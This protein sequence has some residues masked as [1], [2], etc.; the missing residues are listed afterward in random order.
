MPSF[1]PT[2]LRPLGAGGRLGILTSLGSSLPTVRRVVD[3]VL[4][5]LS[6]PPV[7]I[8]VPMSLAHLTEALR[9]AGF[10]RATTWSHSFGVRCPNGRAAIDWL[11][12]SGYVTHPRLE[13]AP[14]PMLAAFEAELARRID[15]A[16]RGD[17]VVLE[18]DLA[19]VVA[20]A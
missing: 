15:R 8:C 12:Q 6:L 19:G 3:E 7:P 2:L 18:F 16:T 20:R 4:G 10:S 5:E 9:V 13:S 11:L 17:E 14:K 1:F